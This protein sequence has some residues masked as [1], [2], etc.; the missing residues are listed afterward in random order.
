M[1]VDGGIGFDLAKAGAHAQE[2]EAA[3]KAALI[4]GSDA[5]L[6]WLDAR[7]HLA[8]LLLTEHG[9]ALRTPTLDAYRWETAGGGCA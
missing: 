9:R 7:P 3:A 1:K 4:L 6:A 2:A 8:G 5:G